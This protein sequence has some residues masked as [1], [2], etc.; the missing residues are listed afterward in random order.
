MRL[1]IGSTRTPSNPLLRAVSLLAGA[2]VL[3]GALFFGALVLAFVVGF[4]VIVSAVAAARL[5][6]IGRKLE[7]AGLGAQS[8]TAA[9]QRR[10]PSGGRVI[11]G[12]FADISE[13]SRTRDRRQD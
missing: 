8:Q 2:V 11:E 6:W 12:E 3:V 10:N 1:I 13:T 7:K 4:L 9:S 5:W